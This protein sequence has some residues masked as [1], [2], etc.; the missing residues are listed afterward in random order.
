MT[1]LWGF[2]ICAGRRSNHCEN[3]GSSWSEISK[4]SST[5]SSCFLSYPSDPGVCTH[6]GSTANKKGVLYKSCLNSWQIITF[7]ECH[8]SSVSKAIRS[9]LSW[10]PCAFPAEKVAV[11]WVSKRLGEKCEVQSCFS[12]IDS[13]RTWPRKDSLQSTNEELGSDSFR[14]YTFSPPG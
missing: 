13:L 8:S 5:P 11:Y 9:L 2:K 7:T 14:T 1:A 12:P 10:G 3:G 6:S 4:H